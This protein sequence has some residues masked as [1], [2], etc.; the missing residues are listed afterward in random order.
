LQF[1]E[2][3]NSIKTIQSIKNDSITN[4]N[5]NPKKSKIFR[6]F[7]IKNFEVITRATFISIS[8]K[9]KPLFMHLRGGG[10]VCETLEQK[11]CLPL[12]PSV[13]NV[14][15]RRIEELRE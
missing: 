2:I 14:A 13:N 11:H 7:K 3:K 8:D 15:K 10:A 5:S 12:P 4:K 6:N 1:E 9:S